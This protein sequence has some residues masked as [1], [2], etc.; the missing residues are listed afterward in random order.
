V[1]GETVAGRFDAFFEDQWP[2]VLGYCCSLVGDRLLGEELA[3]EAFVRVYARFPVLREP[4]PY[5]FRVATNLARD[6][7]ARARREE[8][9]AELRAVARHV[10]VDPHLLDVV[11]R[12]PRRLA[13]VVLLHYYAD[14]PVDEVASVLR[15]PRGTVGRQLTE[16]RAALAVALEGHRD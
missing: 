9:E 7:A 15:R 3:Q 16:A 2:D 14:L 4:R 13:E 11:H 6:S 5:T 12:L 8:P 1:L 10:G